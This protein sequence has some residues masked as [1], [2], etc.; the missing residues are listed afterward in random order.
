MDV[1][2]TPATRGGAAQDCPYQ[3]GSAADEHHTLLTSSAR[4]ATLCSLHWET[5]PLATTE[6]EI[7]SPEGRCGWTLVACAG[8]HRPQALVYTGPCSVDICPVRQRWA[9]L[10]GEQL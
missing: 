5:E 7:L 10:W 3:Q 9:S 6:N 2:D 1:V 4:C 8:T